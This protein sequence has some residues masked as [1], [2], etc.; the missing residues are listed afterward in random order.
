MAT[1]LILIGG[2]LGFFSGITAYTLFDASIMTALLIW[3]ASGP[4]VALVS[5]VLRHA[6][7][8]Q[9]HAPH[10]SIETA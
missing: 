3:A 10:R 8:A 4:V 1:V 2:I 7:Q 6:P 9:S 5:I